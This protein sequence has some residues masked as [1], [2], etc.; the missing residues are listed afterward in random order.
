M[1]RIKKRSMVFSG[2]AIAILLISYVQMD[3]T[4]ELKYQTSAENFVTTTKTNETD[5]KVTLVA[6]GGKSEDLSKYDFFS[7][8][9]NMPVVFS[10]SAL[11][12]RIKATIF[13]NYVS[14]NGK[15]LFVTPPKISFLAKKDSKAELVTDW[16]YSLKENRL[17]ITGRISGERQHI[18]G[19]I[20]RS[21][22]FV[23]FK[24][25]IK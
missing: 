17:F 6:L 22:D 15:M 8:E 12:K 18:D 1:G 5:L 16:G 10:N 7:Y 14:Q 24:I 25:K 21:I 23:T 11:N 9:T 4:K 13:F 2:L 20:D 19:R 3:N